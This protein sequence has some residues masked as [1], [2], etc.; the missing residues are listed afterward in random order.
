MKALYL[1]TNENILG[2]Y[3]NKYKEL[4]LKAQ[5]QQIN[6][7]QDFGIIYKLKF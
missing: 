5:S 1:V 2:V 6:G 3:I 7:T 4:M